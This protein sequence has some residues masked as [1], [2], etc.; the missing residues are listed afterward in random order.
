MAGH[1]GKF[2][3]SAA[4]DISA[5]FS[6]RQASKVASSDEA[7]KLSNPCA[8]NH[9]VGL[10]R[11]LCP[12]AISF[13]QVMVRALI[14][15]VMLANP[16][17]GSGVDA[18]IKSSAPT[19]QL[20]KPVHFLTSDGGDLIAEPGKYTVESIVGARLRLSA[21][22]QSP[23]F[24]EALSTTHSEDLSA[25]VALTVLGDDEDL[26]HVVLLLPSGTGLDAVGSLTGIRPRGA[27]LVPIS[28]VQIT[29]AM[30]Q[31]TVIVRDHRDSFYYELAYFHAPIHYQDTD[32]SR[33]QGDY[34]T[35]FDYD[36][37]WAGRD[38]WDNMQYS[39]L[40]AYVYYSVIETTSH[41]FSIRL[42]SSTRLV[43]RRRGHLSWSR[44]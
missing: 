11:H 18:A 36:G 43:G 31:N 14:T 24:V 3:F 6:F 9:H 19:V 7:T 22:G 1:C 41:W 23:V 8:A 16:M 5:A 33:P 10:A 25:P 44:T 15:G 40:P 30:V 26:L 20:F 28:P 21:E 17:G 12:W 38:N 32:S 42:L 4:S 29:G 37:N 2:R 39:R 35:R 34:I 27:S 13:N